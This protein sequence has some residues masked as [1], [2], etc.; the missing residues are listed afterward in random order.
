MPNISSISS[1][2]HS[3]FQLIS[4]LKA[5]KKSHKSMDVLGHGLPGSLPH[6]TYLSCVPHHAMP[7]A[8]SERTLLRD[9]FHSTS[10]SHTR[11]TH[12]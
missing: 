8:A 6:P 5:K 7:Q 11:V 12:T 1:K 2:D 10:S 9:G 3:F 4:K